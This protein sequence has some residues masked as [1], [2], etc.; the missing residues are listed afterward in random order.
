M[1]KNYLVTGA[2]GFIGSHVVDLVLKRDDVEKIYVIDF[3]G[4]G[5]NVDNLSKDPRVE[6]IAYNLVNA[7]WRDKVP[8]IDYII[9][10]AAESHVDRSITD[11][12]DF[13]RSNVIGTVNVLELARE[14]NSRMVHVSTDEVYGH[15]G[16]DDE[17][18]TEDT[19]LAPRSPYS[20]SKAS[21]DLLALSYVTTFGTNVSITRCCNNYGPR[22]DDEKLIPTVINKLM[23]NEKVPVYGDGTNVREWIHVEDHAKAILEVLDNGE[24]GEVF[25]VPGSEEM[26]NL[27][28]IKRL[29]TE[30]YGPTA[31]IEDHIEF[32]KDRAG[33]DIRYSLRSNKT[34]KAV[35]D[36]RSFNLLDTVMYFKQKNS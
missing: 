29:V 34:L 12:L 33:H 5:S 36:Q 24:P 23:A 22:Q 26:N 18:F 13:V 15:L 31:D 8:H 14:D 1:G 20:S 17:P 4:Y 30:I 6:L 2:A 9:H 35:E 7:N 10:L 19:C 16:L 27:E 11:P 28:I 3:L 25:N 21:S 32:V